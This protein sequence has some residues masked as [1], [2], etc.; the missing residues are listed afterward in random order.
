MRALANTAVTHIDDFVY[1]AGGDEAKNFSN[2]FFNSTTTLLCQVGYK[3]V[4]N[5]SLITVR[6]KQ[7]VS[8]CLFP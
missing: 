6:P 3:L 7:S 4:N 1:A 5:D 2:S 8:D